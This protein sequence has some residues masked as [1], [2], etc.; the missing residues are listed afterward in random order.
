MSNYGRRAFSYS[1][2]HAW[3]LLAENVQKIDIYG[4]LQTLSKDV[5]IRADYAFSAL[6]TV[7]FSFNGLYKCT[8]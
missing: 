7:L 6:E 8:F 1:G 5:F 3:N 4:H 2:P